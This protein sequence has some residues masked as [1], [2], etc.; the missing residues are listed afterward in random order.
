MS[1][2][3]VHEILRARHKLDSNPLIEITIRQ[4]YLD[5]LSAEVSHQAMRYLEIKYGI[6]ANIAAALGVDRS[7]ISK[8]N[9]RGRVPAR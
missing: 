9:R 5:G 8:M 1:A 7:T 4:T 6:Q 3:D 2:V